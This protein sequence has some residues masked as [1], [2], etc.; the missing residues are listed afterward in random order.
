MLSIIFNT[1]VPRKTIRKELLLGVEEGC[2]V[3]GV[4]VGCRVLG[5]GRVGPKCVLALGLTD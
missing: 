3:L 1:S 5:S 2:R 4:E